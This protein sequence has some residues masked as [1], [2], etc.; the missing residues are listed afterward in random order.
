[1]QCV[2]LWVGRCVVCRSV[3]RQV[4]SMWILGTMC[5]SV[6]RQVCSVQ[7]VDL[8]DGRCVVCV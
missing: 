2:D 3:G 1:M 8:W 7:Y 5:R 4:C 6:G